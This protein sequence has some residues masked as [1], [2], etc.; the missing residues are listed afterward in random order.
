ME[1]WDRRN[2]GRDIVDVKL[3]SS[4]RVLAKTSLMSVWK[5]ELPNR[6]KGILGAN[7]RGI[8]AGVQPGD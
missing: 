1:S 2:P 7:R 3:E 8:V 6:G 4:C 5:P